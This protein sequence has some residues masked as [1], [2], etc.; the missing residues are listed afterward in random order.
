MYSYEQAFQASLVYF[1]GD[2]LA[3][4]TWMNKYAIK[5]NNLFLEQSPDDMHRRMA[6]EFAR[7]EKREHEQTEATG[8]TKPARIW[9]NTQGLRRRPDF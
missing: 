4:T 5:E 2:E 8:Q 7:K 6:H 3:A 9:H 1:S